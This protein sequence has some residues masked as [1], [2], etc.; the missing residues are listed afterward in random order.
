MEVMAGLAPGDEIEVTYERAGDSSD[1][2]LTL[3]ANPEDESRP[4]I[5]ILIRTSYET[6]PLARPTTKSIPASPPD[7]SPWGRT[8]W[9]WTR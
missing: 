3:G 2:P 8:W 5:G 6:I 1:L 7:P 4:Q 9:P